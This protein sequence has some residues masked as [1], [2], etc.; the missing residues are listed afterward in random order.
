MVWYIVAK[1]PHFRHPVAVITWLDAHAR[2]QAVEYDE[3]EVA[4]YH[5]PEEC[6]ILGLVIRDDTEGISLYNEETDSTSIRGLSHIPR[7]MIK[8]VEYVTLSPMRTKKVK[9]CESP[10]PLPS[11]PFPSSP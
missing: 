7:G 1:K 11:S 6:T 9:P 10:P 4:Q 8:S 5:R 3:S 2:S